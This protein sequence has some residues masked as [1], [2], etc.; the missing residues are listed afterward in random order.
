MAPKPYGKGTGGEGVPGM[1]CAPPEGRNMAHI[2][3]TAP[4][5]GANARRLANCVQ[6]LRA[7]VNFN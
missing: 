2:L 5:S 7:A 3:I 4:A 6:E 1:P